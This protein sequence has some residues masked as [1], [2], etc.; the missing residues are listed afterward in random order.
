[1]PLHHLSKISL[2]S[3][4]TVS[5]HSNWGFKTR[6]LTKI[7][8][9]SYFEIDILSNGNRIKLWKLVV[10][11]VTNSKML[12][13]QLQVFNWKLHY[14]FIYVFIYSSFFLFIYSLIWQILHQT[15]E[16]NYSMEDNTFH[17]ILNSNKINT[18]H[19]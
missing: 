13:I 2:D 1:M 6:C 17:R 18:F 10:H 4:I 3:V 15:A 14:L 7:V 19:T 5:S 8:Y 16:A 11:F 9:N 12:N